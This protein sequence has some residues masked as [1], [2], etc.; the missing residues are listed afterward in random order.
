MS[1]TCPKCKTANRDQARFC[2]KCNAPLPGETPV[3]YCAAGRHPMDPGW[4]ECPY[5]KME[6]EAK[7]KAVAGPGTPPRQGAGR[8]VTVVE[9]PVAGGEGAAAPSPVSGPRSP[10]PAPGVDRKPTVFAAP[11]VGEGA[12]PQPAQRRIVALLVTYSWRA[13]GEVFPV[14]EGR[15]YLGSGRECDV[16]LEADPQLSSRHA[17]IV[18]R[19][20]DFWI[21][22][23]TSMNG[24]L[25][26]DVMIEEKR[27]LPNYSKVKTG[28]TVWRFIV[29]E[30]RAES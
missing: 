7:A 12:L 4:T 8:R 5:C 25:V 24:T 22:D 27:R 18:Y 16:R 26:D 10:S 3:R 20:K 29:V 28:A 21:D 17:S 6:G 13:D 1:K 11:G 14:R 19:G 9:T 15:N 23:E 30:P 2:M